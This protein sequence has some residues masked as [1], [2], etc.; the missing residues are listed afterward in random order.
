MFQIGWEVLHPC[1]GTCARDA[2]QWCR[3]PREWRVESGINRTFKLRGWRYRE[4]DRCAWGLRRTRRGDGLLPG[5]GLADAVPLGLGIGNANVADG[6]A[7]DVGED[8][9]VGLADGEG[10][11]VGVGV[12]GGGIM[13]SQ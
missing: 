9:V 2:R 11:G 4:P 1:L 13:F 3:H 5:V 10:V 6:D 7:D 12:G 8:V